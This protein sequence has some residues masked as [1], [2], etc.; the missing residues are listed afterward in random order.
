MS[1]GFGVCEQGMETRTSGVHAVPGLK[2]P[3]TSFYLLN[4]FKHLLKLPKSARGSFIVKHDEN[5]QV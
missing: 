2:L 1:F 4:R 3:L 5:K